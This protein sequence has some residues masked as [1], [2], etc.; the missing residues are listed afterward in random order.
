METSDFPG[1]K[2]SHLRKQAALQ[3]PTED[4]LQSGVV[5][6]GAWGF[7]FKDEQL[8]FVGAGFRNLSLPF[9][10]IQARATD[11]RRTYSLRVKLH[12]SRCMEPAQTSCPELSAG[13]LV[14]CCLSLYKF[15]SLSLRTSIWFRLGGE[16]F[17]LRSWCEVT[18][19]G[20]QYETFI[21]RICLV[22]TFCVPSWGL[23]LLRRLRT[24]TSKLRY[25]GTRRCRDS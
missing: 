7:G 4:D 17:G 8:G 1:R 2:G 19:L 21:K 25:K 14:F 3:K 22:Y 6:L 16:D 18:S 15:C 10:E 11:V 24:H 5:K 9:S 12:G 23:I 13:R 20:P